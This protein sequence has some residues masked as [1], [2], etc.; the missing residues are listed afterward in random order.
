MNS[1]WS[2]ESIK[3]LGL[4][5]I[6]CC[7]MMWIGRSEIDKA[8]ARLDRLVDYIMERQADQTERQIE[9]EKRSIA[10]LE[11]NTEVLKVIHKDYHKDHSVAAGGAP[12]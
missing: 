10:A 9:N 1:L 7:A 8:S 5:T 12:K 2:L 11:N 6:L 4:P 3:S